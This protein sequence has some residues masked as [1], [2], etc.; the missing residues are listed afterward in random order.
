MDSFLLFLGNPLPPILQH[1]P[2]TAS[3]EK[4]ESLEQVSVD[5]I[6]SSSPLSSASQEVVPTPGEVIMLQIRR[7]MVQ[8]SATPSLERRASLRASSVGDTASGM[9]GSGGGAWMNPFRQFMSIF[10]NY[11][12]SGGTMHGSML[13]DMEEGG[14]SPEQ[15]ALWR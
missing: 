14:K 2:G 12:M 9:S 13:L 8:V 1:D 4:N 10:A 6:A 3:Q 15:D 11:P 5:K 7:E